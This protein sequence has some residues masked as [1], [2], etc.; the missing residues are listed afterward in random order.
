ML[1]SMMFPSLVLI[2]ITAAPRAT[3]VVQSDQPG[4]DRRDGPA[5]LI[6]SGGEN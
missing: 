3:N 4:A 2:S 6:G 1:L 5:K